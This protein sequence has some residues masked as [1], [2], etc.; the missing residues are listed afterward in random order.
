MNTQVGYHRRRLADVAQA[1]R[2]ARTQIGREQGSRAQLTAHQQQRLDT[3][4][5]HAANSSPFYRRWFAQ[6]G[7]LGAEPVELQR[8]P[9]LDKSLLMEHFDE[10]VCDP[11]LRRDQLLDWV[12]MLTR[13]QLYLGRYRVLVTSGS[14]GGGRAC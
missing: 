8:L 1:L 9:V 5:R 6:T 3:V 11:R 12:G 13:D 7:A 2:Q 4:V 14:S 10:L